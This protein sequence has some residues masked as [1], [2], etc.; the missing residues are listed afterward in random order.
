MANVFA[1]G[2]PATIKQPCVG[3]WE[4]R[5]LEAAVENCS[6]ET[7]DSAPSCFL[8]AGMISVITHGLL[9]CI[10]TSTTPSKAGS[11]Y[12]NPHPKRKK[13]S[14]VDPLAG[15]M[16]EGKARQKEEEQKGSQR[17]S[18]TENAAMINREEKGV[19]L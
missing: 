9:I 19:L 2:F 1:E 4:S 8:P 18:N 17:R 11:V 16:F 14:A 5:Q 3:L 12:E 6:M 10:Y 7:G 15:K 13:P